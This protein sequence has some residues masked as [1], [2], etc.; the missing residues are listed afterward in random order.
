MYDK[1]D[2]FESLFTLIHNIL[3]AYIIHIAYSYC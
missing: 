1:P 3:L 2:K